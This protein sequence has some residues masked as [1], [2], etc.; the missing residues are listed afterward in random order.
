MR[1]HNRKPFAGW[2]AGPLV[3]PTL[4]RK[5]WSTPPVQQPI[6]VL[7]LLP[8]PGPTT[9]LPETLKD[10]FRP[11]SLGAPP[12]RLVA[13]N[14]L[15]SFGFTCAHSLALKLGT[16]L[17]FLRAM[18]SPPLSGGNSTNFNNNYGLSF[19]F[20]CSHF[21]LVHFCV[22]RAPYYGENRATDYSTSVPGRSEH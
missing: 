9:T 8:H 18:L 12:V 7:H 19:L 14:V 17:E 11:I 3:Q 10:L 16:L 2:L 13:E 6:R 22:F 20:P 1:Y 4:S 5:A 21:Y 15:L